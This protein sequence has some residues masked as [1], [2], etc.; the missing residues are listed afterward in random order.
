MKGMLQGLRKAEMLLLKVSLKADRYLGMNGRYR[1]P[2][3]IAVRVASHPLRSA[4]LLAVPISALA[5]MT[6]GA[7]SDGTR[8]L[9]AALLGTGL[10]L[11]FALCL[12]LE[13]LTQLH[14]E[15]VGHTPVPPL[16][17]HRP[18]PGGLGRAVAY[19]CLGWG[20]LWVL[21][22][23]LERAK[24]TPVSWLF[25]GV[26]AG[27]FVLGATAIGYLMERKRQRVSRQAA[28]A[29]SG[30]VRSVDDDA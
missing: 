26:F 23:G 16:P 14:H 19:V 29:A 20:V 8:F 9:Q 7:F 17:A 1:P 10:T 18:S 12:R 22:W 11:F 2:G 28:S 25:S 21:V 5:G 15:R 4:A 24:G 27:L 30:T 13:R 3:P 6:F